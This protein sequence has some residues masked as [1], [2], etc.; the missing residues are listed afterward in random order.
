M[1]ARWFSI[2]V[3]LQLAAFV[4]IAVAYSKRHDVSIE[5]AYFNRAAGEETGAVSVWTGPVAPWVIAAGVLLLAALAA[6]VL[7]RRARASAT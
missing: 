7:D 2:A 5:G 3:G 4:C 6:F 1:R